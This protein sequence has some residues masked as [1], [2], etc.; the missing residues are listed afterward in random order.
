MVRR[1]LSGFRVFRA[2]TSPLKL[3]SVSKTLD[4]GPTR[5]GGDD[6]ARTGFGHNADEMPGVQSEDGAAVRAQVAQ[7]G[8]AA[9]DFLHGFEVRRQKQEGH[10][11]DLA[12][13]GVDEADLGREDAMNIVG[14]DGDILE[15]AVDGG[16]DVLQAEESVS[17]R[18]QLLLG[19]EE[20]LRMGEIAGGDEREA[21]DLGPVS[22]VVEGHVPG[23]GPAELGMYV[24]VGD[25]SHVEEGLS[26]MNTKMECKGDFVYFGRASSWPLRA[27]SEERAGSP[28]RL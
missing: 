18:F 8:E 4:S 14:P 19:Q 13:L 1:N 25:E 7:A 12:L 27:Y 17:C 15:I 24:K 16:E 2:S 21:F 10:L 11:S 26:V 9:V 23:G 5:G 20:P 22:D 28:S 6:A 3:K